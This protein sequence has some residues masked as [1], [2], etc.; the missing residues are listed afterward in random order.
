MPSLGEMTIAAIKVLSNRDN[1]FILM[2]EGGM[3][4]QA[5]HRGNARQALSEVSAFD[6]AIEKTLDLLK[7]EIDESLIIVT[8]DHAHTLSINGYPDRGNS[9]LGVSQ[10]SRFDTIPY[11]TLSYATGH[12]GYQV[13]IR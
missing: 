8:A 7:N 3:I 10:N 12:F 2:V 1:G 5:H 9:I 11:T 4:D 13:K 6:D